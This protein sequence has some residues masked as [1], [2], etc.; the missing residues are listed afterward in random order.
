MWEPQPLATLRAS[1]ACTGITLPFT[2]PFTRRR[3]GLRVIVEKRVLCGLKNKQVKIVA[4]VVGSLDK[5]T[6]SAN[7]I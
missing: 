3:E 5:G 7:Y 1:T 4:I 2:L 6:H